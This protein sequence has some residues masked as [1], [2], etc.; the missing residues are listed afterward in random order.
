[1]ISVG[2]KRPEEA[3]TGVAP[4][5]DLAGALAAE[6][7]APEGGVE[8]GFFCGEEEVVLMKGD[9][10]RRMTLG[11]NGQALDGRSRR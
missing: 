10:V 5:G 3:L 6:V 9:G 2:T 8:A 1:M 4:A 7:E 11:C